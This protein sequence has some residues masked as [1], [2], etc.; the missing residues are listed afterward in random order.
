VSGYVRIH[1]ALLG[2]PAFRNDAEAMAFAWMVAKAAWKPTK[3]RYKG[4]DITLQRGEL[5]VSIRDFAAR[6][7]RPKGWV[8]RLFSRLRQHRMIE[9]KN[10][11]QVGTQVGTHGGTIG[12][13]P[14]QVIT[15]CNY[16]T[17]Q[18][19]ATARETPNGTPHKTDAGQ[20][21]DT[22]QVREEENKEA[23]ASC[24]RAAF[25][26]P[27]GVTA[28]QWQA[29]RKQRKKPINDRSY[30]LLCNKLVGLAEAGWPPGEMI[31]LAIERGWETVFEPRSQANVSLQRTRP[32]LTSLVR[33]ANAACLDPEDHGGAGPALPAIGHG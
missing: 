3:E 11:T 14:A 4:H 25:P 28:E 7:D 8:E 30:T 32:N 2:H 5:T 16:E 27:L 26:P 29:F 18:A 23:I 22:E 12:G 21:Q 17:F 20:R 6:M 19:D 33:A 24:I 10:G 13:T 31:D 9:Q 15:I 1:R